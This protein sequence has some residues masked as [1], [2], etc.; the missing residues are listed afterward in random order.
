MVRRSRD[1][2]GTSTGGS[3]KKKYFGTD[4]VRG[5]ANAKLTP[6][7]AFAIGQ[8]AGR[9]LKKN[10]ATPRAAIGRD[11]RRSG[12][13]LGAA[14]AAGFNSA[15]IDTIV[16]GVAPTP[17]IAYVTRFGEFGLGAVISA[18][19]NPAPDNG[20]KLISSTGSKV[21]DEF[22]L[23][24][25]SLLYSEFPDRPVGAEVGRLITDRSALSAYEDFL[26]GLVPERLEGMKIAV[27]C[28]NGAAYEIAPR[29]LERLGAEV[30]TLHNEPDGD[31]INFHCGATHPETVQNYV[32]SSASAVG[33]AFDGDADRAVFSDD[34]GRLINGDR[35]IAMWA[36][37]WK[38]DPP[39]VVGTVMSNSGFERY[40][41]SKGIRLER[42]KVGD[43]Y[44]SEQI[45][46]TGAK[47][48][49]EQSG[50]IIFPAH[51]PTGDGLVTAL[52][53]FRVIK[54]ENQLA[55]AFF[56]R[57]ENWPQL[58]VNI[59]VADRE[60]WDKVPEVQAAIEAANEKLS[61]NGRLNVRASGTQP[62]IRV[63]V[64]SESAETRDAVAKD[65]VECLQKYAGGKVYSQVDL[66]HALGD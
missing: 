27:D 31:N 26:V 21:S 6:E 57:F 23:E 34:K 24:L 25:E 10:G 8:A 55:S 3:L 66:T 59:E 48:G 50:H 61:S 41:A 64:E 5:V 11:T 62:M 37:H 36:D 13:M 32:V 9:L 45:S 39:V 12:P 44:V 42:A 58:L 17:A 7:L 40:M 22:E 38:V 2:T 29:V 20:I 51:G 16:L 43:K 4:G 28:A 35:T 46:T 49:G 47:I 1:S 63:M 53:L 15:G 54:R 56:D 60:T 18:S 14:L 30:L 19:H 52:E 33:V 65:L